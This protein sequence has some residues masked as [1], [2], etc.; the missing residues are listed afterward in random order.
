MLSLVLAIALTLPFTSLLE[1]ARS[2]TPGPGLYSCGNQRPVLV[3]RVGAGAGKT[4]RLV[5]EPM[6]Y[7]FI[8][9]LMSE[10]G[11]MEY[12]WFGIIDSNE[13]RSFRV[14]FEGAREEVMQRVP[15]LCD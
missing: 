1:F 14:E 8:L 2:G 13:E 10:Q 3:A 5:Y 6:D 15:V 7:R 12:S 4:Y 9:S 11:D